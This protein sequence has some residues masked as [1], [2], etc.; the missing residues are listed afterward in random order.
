MYFLPCSSNLYSIE[1]FNLAIPEVREMS[2]MAPCKNAFRSFVYVRLILP[3][4]RQLVL[5][6]SWMVQ[7]RSKADAIFCINEASGPLPASTITGIFGGTTINFGRLLSF[8][9]SSY[10]RLRFFEVDPDACVSTGPLL[11]LISKDEWR[12]TKIV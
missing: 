12:S 6:R 4:P 10:T 1:G 3:F 11:R 7:L 8:G 9:S 5:R 2:S